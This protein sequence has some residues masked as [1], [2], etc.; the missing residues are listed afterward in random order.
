MSLESVAISAL[1]FI[2][3]LLNVE[4]VPND[5]ASGWAVTKPWTNEE[6]VVVLEAESKQIVSNC[7]TA[8]DSYI[9]FPVVIHGAHVLSLDGQPVLRFSDPE[10]K[11]PRSFY[12][13]PTL[14]C[15]HITSGTTLHWRVV[16]YSHYFARLAFF[17]SVVKRRPLADFVLETM[18][19]IAAGSLLM[20]ALFCAVVF[21]RKVSLHET[22]SLALS[23]LAMAGY[24]M[25]SV[26][27]AFGINL[28]MLNLH[29]VADLCVWTGLCLFFNTLR[30]EGLISNKV[31]IAYFMNV[32]I[33]VVILLLGKSGDTLQFGTTLPF[34]FTLGLML[35][36]L[37][38]IRKLSKAQGYE[39]SFLLKS[40]SL[41]LFAAA[42]F[43]DIFVVTG[44]SSGYVM[45]S[46]GIVCGLLFLA[47]SVNE[48]INATY[49][50]RDYLQAHLEEEVK[51]KTEQLT[52]RTR[53]LQEAMQK[54]KVTQSELIQ[55]EKLVS[56]GTLA[57]GIAHEINNSLNY[58]NGA[59]RPLE[60]WIASV[61]SKDK[62]KMNSLISIM[63]DGLKLTFE[64][65]NSLRNYTGLNQAKFN[66]LKIKEVIDSVLAILR[67]KIKNGIE[68]KVD[69]DPSLQI[70]GNVVGLNQVFMN[71]IVN[72]VDAMPEGGQ[73]NISAQ[74]TPSEASI[75]IADSGCGIPENIQTRIWE[76]FFTTKEVGK[77]SGLGLHI[78]K[79]E[80]QRHQ[81]K[82]NLSSEPGKGTTFEIVLPTSPAGE[83]KVAA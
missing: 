17:P 69:I 83:S 1:M 24:F 10:F 52:S 46:V 43:N 33:A 36:T 65:I 76:P 40:L 41:A 64:I 9:E 7:K 42:V 5:P 68:V 57:A 6:R 79:M 38:N 62:E 8:P 78:V 12:G 51:K 23:N 80:I 22:M 75:R 44:L 58:V 59:L 18:N 16:S 2:S 67:N 31:Y 30:I 73:L 34:A 14:Q 32:A 45:L 21:Y 49:R 74:S 61:E 25:G 26:S 54:L 28:D 60:K 27:G 50:E 56:L 37:F 20:M 29:R 19:I 47:L 77:G 39:R 63:K 66:D 72:A 15:K 13:T 81:G 3:G 82:I 4:S 53:E 55:S 70:F 11:H 48:Q 35:A 71:L